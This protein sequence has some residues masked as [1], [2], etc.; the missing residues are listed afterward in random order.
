MI[1]GSPLAPHSASPSELAERLAAERLG[2][3]FLVY[4]DGNGAQVLLELSGGDDRIT[5]GRRPGNTVV[6]GWDAEVSR[7]HAMLELVGDEW[8]LADDG[9][10]SNG[11]FVNGERVAGRRRLRDGDI[12]RF[13]ETLIGFCDPA[14]EGESNVTRV[15][16]E[17][18]LAAGV[19]PAQRR[20]LVA[21]CRPFKD[22]AYATPASNQRIADELVVSVDAVKSHLRAMF[23]AF[24][25]SALP[26]N[27]KRGHLA[28]EALRSGLVS[29]REL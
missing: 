4:R 16:A 29:Q 26:Q 27:E 23:E 13:G 11:S 17:G 8:S 3:P 22:Q 19:S 24:G 1:S 12:L 9:L 7:V 25:L 18:T 6:L 20:V 28:Q 2:E 5:F 21:L 10:S 15:A 14:A